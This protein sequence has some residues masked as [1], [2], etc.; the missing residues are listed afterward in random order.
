MS[1]ISGAPAEAARQ[2]LGKASTLARLALIGV[3]LAAVIAAFGYFG[4]WLTPHD[5][6]P[7]GSPMFSSTSMEFIPAS[8]A[9]MPR[10]WGFRGSLKATAMASASRRRSSFDRG[11]CLSSVASPSGEDSLMLPIRRMP[12]VVWDFSFPFATVNYGEPQ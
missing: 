5:L 11:A 2:R 1:S 9:I 8:V 6:T 4:G 12:C 3:A 10:E 7:R